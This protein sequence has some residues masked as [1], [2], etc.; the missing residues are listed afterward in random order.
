V[1]VKKQHITDMISLRREAALIAQTFVL[2][3]TDKLLMQSPVKPVKSQIDSDD[4]DK[5]KG[6]S[7]T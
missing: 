1:T 3:V 7:Q 6:I 4:Q 2:I 5:T